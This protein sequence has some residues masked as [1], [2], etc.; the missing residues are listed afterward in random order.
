MGYVSDFSSEF[1]VFEVFL[2]DERS[3]PLVEKE[4]EGFFSSLFELR[5]SHELVDF[6]DICS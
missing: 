6:V 5:A 1:I 2:S 4:A 3:A